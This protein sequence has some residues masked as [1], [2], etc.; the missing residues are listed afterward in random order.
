MIGI[1]KEVWQAGD[2]L[3]RAK[4]YWQ[5]VLVCDNDGFNARITSSPSQTI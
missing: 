4:V 5:L 2:R 3:D 1:G